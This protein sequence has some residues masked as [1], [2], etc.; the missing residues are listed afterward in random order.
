MSKGHKLEIRQKEGSEG[1]MTG[2]NT[3]LLLDGKPLKLVQGVKFQVQ[4]NGV[5]KVTLD[6]IANVAVVGQVGEL[7][8]EYIPLKPTKEA[9]NE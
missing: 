4:A 5:A 9:V 6:M 2:A 8:Q 1:I 3:E 7:E